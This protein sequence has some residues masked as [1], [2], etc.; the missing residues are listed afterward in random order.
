MTYISSMC[1]MCRVQ[2]VKNLGC[3]GRR[4]IGHT[5]CLWRDEIC[6]ACKFCFIKGA[7][8]VAM[9]S[10]FVFCRPPVWQTEKAS[11][12]EWQGHIITWRVKVGRE[13][14]I[15]ESISFQLQLL[16]CLVNDFG[17]TTKNYKLFRHSSFLGN[18]WQSI[19]Y[20]A[21]SG[22]QWRSDRHAYCQMDRECGAGLQT[23]HYGQSGAHLATTSAGWCPSHVSS[24]EQEAEDRHRGNKENP[25]DCTCDEY[26]HCIWSVCS[27]TVAAEWILGRLTLPG[28]ADWGT[29][30]QTFVL[31]LPQCVKQ[32]L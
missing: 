32:L 23:L 10:F 14:Q 5:S 7:M 4:N 22:V 18:D 2:V 26:I 30:A 3:F 8:P 11:K 9:A 20:P 13:K 19:W 28:L 12:E 6:I 27:A 1:F 31:G 29:T 24:T 15:W 16:G 21:D 25:Y 17:P